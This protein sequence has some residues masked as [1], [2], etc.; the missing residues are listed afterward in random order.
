MRLPCWNRVLSLSLHLSMLQSM[1]LSSSLHLRA[2]M[3]TLRLRTASMPTAYSM[4]LFTL[5]CADGGQR[6]EIFDWGCSALDAGQQIYAHWW[7]NYIQIGLVAQMTRCL[8]RI[9]GGGGE[10]KS[11][12][13]G[14]G[15]YWLYFPSKSQCKHDANPGFAGP[16]WKTLMRSRTAACLWASRANF[17]TSATS[18]LAGCGWCA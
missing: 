8:L 16:K 17:S 9:L 2:A 4:L 14:Y 13:Y 7:H 11:W 10:R 15:C 18:S 12:R 3:P 1:E 5:L 6:G